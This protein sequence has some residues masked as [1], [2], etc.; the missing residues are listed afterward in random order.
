MTGGLWVEDPQAII[1]YLLGVD[2]GARVFVDGEQVATVV[3]AQYCLGRGGCWAA[4]V[5]MA[6]GDVLPL[7][8]TTKWRCPHN[9][10]LN[11]GGFGNNELRPKQLDTGFHYIR[12]EVSSWRCALM[13]AAPGSL[14]DTHWP[15]LACPRP[16]PKHSTTTVSSPLRECAAFHLRVQQAQGLGVSL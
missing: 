1:F 6:V 5:A 2:D 13:R 4:V 9:A 3:G 14:A 11:S 16:V 8:L 15:L 10:G 7:Q 12:I